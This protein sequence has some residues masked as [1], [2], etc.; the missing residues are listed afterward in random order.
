[1][2]TKKMFM[3][4]AMATIATSAFAQ[5][6][7]VKEAK[8]LN[9]SGE[10]EQ[11][12][13]V[14]TPA[15]TS[16][17]TTDKA[18]AWNLMFTI[19]QSEFNKLQEIEVNN[20]V[21]QTQVAYDT[22]A[23]HRSVVEALKAAIKC[24]EYDRQPNAKGKVKL[25]FRTATAPVAR[26]LRLNIINAG[27]FEYNKKN[28]AGAIECWKLYVDA[29]SEPLFS[30]I[31]EM[32]NDP[33]RSEICYYVG[34]AAY[35]MKDYAT[36]TKYAKFAAEDSAK[37]KDANEIVLFAMKD[38]C[39]TKEDSLNYLNTIKDLHAKNPSESRYF[40]LLM[41]Y[42]SKP[43]R[44]QEMGAWAAEEVTRDPN[45]KMA[46]ALKGEVEM[47]NSKWDDA[48]AS[49]NNAA[50]LDPSFVQ[51]VFNAGVCY[52]SKAIELKDQLADK[53][54]GGLTTENANKVKAVL[55]E[56]KNYL[57][58]ARTLDPDREKVNWAYPL[59]Q[60]Y[61]SLGDKEKSAEME[62]LINR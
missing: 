35:N 9:A 10:F 47:N 41:E 23:M 50:E 44:Q 40:N 49:Y 2:T 46:W 17:A 38:G 36:A 14:L 51:V 25:R 8:K 57:E 31:K 29:A 18:A 59:Y 1:M 61:Y 39:Q 53:K 45:N 30:E 3:M 42:Y 37:A 52:N 21:K 55:A 12:A 54:T 33:Y 4:M 11:A 20:K 43:G 15:L 22:V 34:L 26:N 6:D 58:K 60:I 62:A 5:D 32:A 13:K 19:K 24:D 16:D 56:A 28:M 48:I 7:L 27:M